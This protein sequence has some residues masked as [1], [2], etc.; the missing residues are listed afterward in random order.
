MQILS[1]H[2]QTIFHYTTKKR[3]NLHLCIVTCV[4]YFGFH[5]IYHLPCINECVLKCNDRHVQQVPVEAQFSRKE[6]C[7]W[8]RGLA[9]NNCERSSEVSDLLI[10]KKELLQSCEWFDGDRQGKLIQ[11]SREFH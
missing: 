2:M 4:K 11:Q 3:G 5:G 10:H 7:Q 9:C 1:E 6:V 8:Q